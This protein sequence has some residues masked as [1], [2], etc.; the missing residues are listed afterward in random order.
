MNGR[1][2]ANNRHLG[3]TPAGDPHA[4]LS[5]FGARRLRRRIF[6][7]NIQALTP[8][9]AGGRARVRRKLRKSIRPV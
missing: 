2:W 5:T 3:D 1:R 7:L 4:A 6:A 9:A 8:V